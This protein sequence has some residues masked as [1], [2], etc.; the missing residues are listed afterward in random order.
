MRILTVYAHPDDEAFGP[1]SVLARAVRHGAE[2]DG[3]WLTR[4]EQGAPNEAPPPTPAALGRAR[5]A[6]LRAVARL[7]GYRGVEILDYAD[8]GLARV[9]LE[10]LEGVV[11]ERLRALRP[12]VVLTF[13]PAG[14]T[15]H[16]DHVAVG[17]AASA[18][19]ARG[20]AEGLPPRALFYDAV[21]P[22]RAA[23]MGIA[24]APDG[25]PN[26]W[27]DVRET[28]AVKLA[29]LRLHGRHVAD[30]AERAQALATSGLLEREPLY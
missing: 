4:G 8:G 22:E 12:D 18:A 27:I 7:I 10:E 29:A 15:R 1:S 24:D 2:L 11:L 6:D 30:A 5:A 9:P 19:F 23:E 21:A 20:R 26:T 16:P 17:R 14:I 25:Q 3:L 13:G 28:A